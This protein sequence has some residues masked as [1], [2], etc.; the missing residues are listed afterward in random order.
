MKDRL[1]AFVSGAP[2]FDNLARTVNFTFPGAVGDRTFHDTLNTY[3]STARLDFLATQKI[4]LYGSW[5]YNYSRETG[6]SLPQRDEV[7]GQFNANSTNNPDIYNAGIG[8][9]NPNV[10]YNV[11]ADISITPR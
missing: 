8:T 5:Q 7:H 6:S 4:R 11:G 3:Y 10:L 2:D 1:W 9:V